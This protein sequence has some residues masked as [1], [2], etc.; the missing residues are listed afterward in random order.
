MLDGLTIPNCAKGLATVN[1]D[2]LLVRSKPVTGAVV[3]SLPRGG[4]VTIWAVVDGWAIVQNAA[5]LTG[6]SS[7]RY[8]RLG[9]LT[10]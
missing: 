7:V 10:P 3:G 8:L 9:V 5:G 1:A 6:W 2:K 4:T